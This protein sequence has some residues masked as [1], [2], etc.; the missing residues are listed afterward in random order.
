[1]KL[2]FYNFSVPEKLIA[3]YPRKKREEARLMV[4][5]KKKGKIEHRTFKD[6]P[7]FFKPGDAVV[8]NNSK[9]FPGMLYGY[10]E[11][12]KS[13]IEVSL[14]RELNKE[15]H[16]WDTII[17]PARKIRK[18]NKLYFG[19]LPLVAEVIHN[20]TSRGRTI[21]FAFEGSSEELRKIIYQLGKPPIPELLKRPSEKID[22]IRYQSIYAERDGTIVVPDGSLF[23]T[24]Y[25]LKYLEYKDILL[26]RV[27]LFT[28]PSTLIPLS[29]Q[30]L[31]R[32]LIGSEYYEIETEIA[33]L[34]NETK[35]EKKQICAVGCGT[36]KA[37][38]SSLN[39]ENLIRG[40]K[41][42]SGQFIYPPYISQTA[43]AL[44]TNFHLPGSPLVLT[45]VAFGGTDLMMKAYKEAVKKEYNFFVYGDALLII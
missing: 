30:D 43:T 26:P 40:Y 36:F 16:L 41:G 2:S 19:D 32:Y 27:T 5:H 8:L 20:T 24:K 45:A 38:E 22:E 12:N 35:K 37:M 13:K 28:N 33:T 25:I 42:W 23:F 29:I 6:F 9:V 10:K 21:K 4:V 7:S 3:R 31:G 11:K 39:S 34:L 15:T 1:M 14:L 17:E 44:L 18:G